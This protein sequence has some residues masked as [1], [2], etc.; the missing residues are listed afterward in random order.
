MEGMVRATKKRRPQDILLHPSLVKPTIPKSMNG[1]RF[2]R[3]F[4]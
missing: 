1:N 3:G 4:P 2:S